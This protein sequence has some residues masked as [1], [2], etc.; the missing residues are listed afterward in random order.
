[1]GVNHGGKGNKFS[2]NLEW[3]TLMQIIPYIFKKYCSEFTKMPD[4]SEKLKNYWQEGVCPL[5]LAPV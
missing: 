4:P 2:Q 3:G 1:M 5:D